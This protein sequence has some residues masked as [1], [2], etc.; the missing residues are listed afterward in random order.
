M[1]HYKK[2]LALHK[3][4]ELIGEAESILGWDSEVMMPEG[5]SDN[6][7]E[8]LATLA[9]IA[10]NKSTS[11][12][13]KDL[14]DRAL[15]EKKTLSKTQKVNL[16]ELKRNYVHANCLPTDLVSELTKVSKKC[17]MVWRT[18]KEQNDYMKVRPIFGELLKLVRQEAKC[19]AEALKVSPYQAM[20]DQYDPYRKLEEVDT[21]FAE[22]REKLPPLI[23]QIRAKQGMKTKLHGKFP[24]EKQKELG[25]SYMKKVGFDFTQGR[26]DISTHPFCGGT[27]DDVRITTRYREDEFIQSFEGIMH[28]TGHALYEQGLPKAHRYEPIG[29]AA[30]IATHE[31]QSLFV[32]YQICRSKTF[33]KDLHKQLFKYFKLDKQI[34]T[35]EHFYQMVN[36]VEPSFIRVEADEVTYPLHVIMRYELEKAM[37]EGDLEVDELPN[38]WNSKMKKYLGIV[39]AN[40]GEGCMQDI[41]WFGGGFGYFPSYTLGALTAAQL[42]AKMSTQLNFDKHL[43]QQNFLPIIEWL[44]QNV[45][46][47]GA[48]YSGDGLLNEVTGASLNPKFF[49][50]YVANKFL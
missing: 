39:P 30:G 3:E 10:H 5:S 16:A 50:D 8:Q 37:V 24:I 12:E 25:L 28:E 48:L 14:L 49:L 11:Q 33:L 15:A 42:K 46:S 44:R 47:K 27:P 29:Q 40:V 4:I 18:A 13:Y 32:E 34:W 22:L 2:L 26:L 43:S 9:V 36:W 7:A 31:S 20:L 41:H 38:A 17:E 21:I 35:F 6:R 45:H 1:E 23:E 19:K